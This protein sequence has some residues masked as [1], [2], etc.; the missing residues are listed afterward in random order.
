MIKYRLQLYFYNAEYVLGA[1]VTN[2]LSSVHDEFRE[3]FDLE[4]RFRNDRAGK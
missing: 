3:Q 4:P 1:V 2:W